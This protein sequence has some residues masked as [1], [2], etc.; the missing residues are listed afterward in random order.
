MSKLSVLDAYRFRCKVKGMC[1]PESPENTYPW[2]YVKTQIKTCEN[3]DLKTAEV[4]FV[5]LKSPVQ[6]NAPAPVIYSARKTV[7]RRGGGGHCQ[8]RNYHPFSMPYF[9][10]S[11]KNTLCRRQNRSP[12]HKNSFGVHY[13]WVL[14][15]PFCALCIGSGQLPAKGLVGIKSAG[16][17]GGPMGPAAFSVAARRGPPSCHRQGLS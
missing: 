9:F 3:P 8:V 17:L 1:P 14:T 2:L 15:S 16:S 6:N 10:S 12:T 4:A 5:E 7:I 13:V 11:E